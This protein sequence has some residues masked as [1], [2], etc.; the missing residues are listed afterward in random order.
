MSDYA[1]SMRRARLEGGLSV[2][3]LSEKSG[4]T[5]MTIYSVE[6]GARNPSLTT[7]VRLAS[8][9]RLSL[10]DYVGY[11]TPHRPRAVAWR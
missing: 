3:E 10:D 5:P 2:R 11:D 6:R 4:V 1:A 9:L 7:L 8:A